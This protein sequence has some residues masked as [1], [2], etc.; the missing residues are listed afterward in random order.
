MARALG[1]SYRNLIRVKIASPIDIGPGSEPKQNLSI[2]CFVLSLDELGMRHSTHFTHFFVI[3]LHAS[4]QVRVRVEDLR[5]ES[6]S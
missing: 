3:A 4:P 1:L 2:S 5:H 6:E